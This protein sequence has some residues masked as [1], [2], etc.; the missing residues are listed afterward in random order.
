MRTLNR[1]SS[2]F[3]KLPVLLVYLV[4]FTV[5]LF[6]NI[7]TAQHSHPV[8]RLSLEQYLQK[9]PG[10]QSLVKHAS[11]K[12]QVHSKLRL[13][14]RFQPAAIPVLGAISVELPLVYA[15]PLQ[16]RLPN[17]VSLPSIYPMAHALRGPP[18]A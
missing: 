10:K 13:N 5:Q 11:T 4:F 9:Q 16:T 6:Y 18:V 12:T 2:Y 3:I 7:D 8:Y 15:V 17:T 1:L 14:K